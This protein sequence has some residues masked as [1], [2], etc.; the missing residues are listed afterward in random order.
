MNKY[1]YWK[2]IK[3]ECELLWKIEILNVTIVTTNGTYLM[4][5]G[6]WELIWAVLNVTVQMH[7]DLIAVEMVAE[8]DFLDQLI[9]I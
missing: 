9:L 2:C 7:I 5:M 6:K 4:E 3:N 1:S 8:E